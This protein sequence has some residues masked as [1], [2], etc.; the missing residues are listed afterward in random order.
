MNHPHANCGLYYEPHEFGFD[1][2]PSPAAS[3]MQKRAKLSTS[4]YANGSK[5]QRVMPAPGGAGGLRRK[6]CSPRQGR[7]DGADASL[8]HVRKP[9]RFP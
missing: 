7:V 8:V 6:S 9:I 5:A 3:S 1:M 4:R 2:M